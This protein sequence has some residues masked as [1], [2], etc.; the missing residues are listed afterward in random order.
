[1]FLLFFIVYYNMIHILT[2]I[3]FVIWNL[4]HTAGWTDKANKKLTGVAIYNFHYIA[5]T[6]QTREG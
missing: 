5:T 3:K 4:P 6:F 2:R 1:M